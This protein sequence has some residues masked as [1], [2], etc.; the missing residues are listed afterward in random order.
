M[1]IEIFHAFYLQSP[2]GTVYK[3]TIDNEG[4]LDAQA[5]GTLPVN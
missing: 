1:E 4:K 2:D 3:I 5:V